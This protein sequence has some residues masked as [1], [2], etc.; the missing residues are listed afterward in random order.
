M[1]FRF[2]G[3]V[4][5]GFCS[6]L[7]ELFGC[8]L[9][10]LFMRLS[11]A[12]N[13]F[14]G[15]SCN[16]RIIRG[17]K[18]LQHLPWSS[19]WMWS[20][21]P[22]ILFQLLSWHINVVQSQICRRSCHDW[23]SSLLLSDPW[24]FVLRFEGIAE[25]RAYVFAIQLGFENFILFGTVSTASSHNVIFLVTLLWLVGSFMVNGVTF[26]QDK[27]LRLCY[28]N[29]SWAL[30]KITTSLSTEWIRVLTSTISVIKCTC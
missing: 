11:A 27:L 19:A 17:V 5:L 16:I 7:D 28:M 15:L 14:R 10:Q 8:P 2:E 3:F 18:W 13:N 26:K 20:F 4:E 21:P 29:V 22:E 6:N 24:M 9:L 12:V 1:A 23:M 25:T 30:L